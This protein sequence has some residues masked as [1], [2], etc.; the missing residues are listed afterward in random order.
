MKL[1]WYIEETD[2]GPSYMKPEWPKTMSLGRGHQQYH[3]TKPRLQYQGPDGKWIDIETFVKKIKG[4]NVIDYEKRQKERI[5]D[6][7]PFTADE[8]EAFKKGMKKSRCE[9]CS[10][11]FSEGESEVGCKDCEKLK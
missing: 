8:L 5:K 4:Q 1:R 9:Y 3:H 2:Y 10:T 11:H 7:M 6:I